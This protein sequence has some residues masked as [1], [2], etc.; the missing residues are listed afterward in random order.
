MMAPVHMLTVAE[1]CMK[2]VNSEMTKRILANYKH[3][4]TFSCFQSIWFKVHDK[5][6]IYSSNQLCQNNKNL[7][8]LWNFLKGGLITAL[9]L[10]IQWRPIRTLARSPR[11]IQSDMMMVCN[12]HNQLHVLHLL[13][14]HTVNLLS[15]GNGPAIP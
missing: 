8:P 15:Q 2:V 11:M 10:I 6:N 7:Y 9:L 14:Q 5:I 13:N 1:C 4:L 12:I 3:R